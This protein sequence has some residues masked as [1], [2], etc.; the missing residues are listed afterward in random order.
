MFYVL[1]L[2][3]LFLGGSVSIFSRKASSLSFRHDQHFVG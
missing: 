1:A 3:M 2:M